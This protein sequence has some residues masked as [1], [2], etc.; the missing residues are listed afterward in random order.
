VVTISQDGAARNSGG[1][2]LETAVDRLNQAASFQPDIACLPEL[3]ARSDA[4]P[5]PGPTSER[6]GE[7]ARKHFCYVVAG[8]KKLSGGRTYN[9]A[10]LLDRQGRLAGQYDKMYPT[11]GELQQGTSP[12]NPDPPVFDTDFGR[13]GIQICF[14]VNWWDNWKR[15]K[16][17]GA[18]IIF[19]PAAYPAATQLSALA[20]MNQYFVVSSAGTRDS[21][22]YDITGRVLAVSGTY[23]HWAGA[24][25]PLGRRLFEIDFHVGSGRR[26]GPRRCWTRNPMKWVWRLH[27]ALISAGTR[28]SG[29]RLTDLV[30]A[31]GKS[32]DGHPRSLSAPGSL[33]KPTC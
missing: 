29:V 20:L 30:C 24:V 28:V 5:V 1:D 32:Y 13:I 2:L 8:V 17:K 4:E 27:L 12:G 21:R 19:F 23:Q 16:E 7:W 22:I 14:D 18:K 6:L 25:L 10:I 11:E 15:L 33:S 3:F 31:A 9:T 26:P